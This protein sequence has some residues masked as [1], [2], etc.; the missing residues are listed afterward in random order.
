M[1]AMDSMDSRSQ[2]CVYLFHGP[3]SPS[4]AWEP[5]CHPGQAPYVFSVASRRVGLP[6]SS[7]Y[8]HHPVII[9]RKAGGQARPHCK[10]KGWPEKSLEG[11][12]EPFALGSL[13]LAELVS[14]TWGLP[15]VFPAQRRGWSWSLPKGRRV[16][17]QDP[18]GELSLDSQQLPEG[19]GD[20]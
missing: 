16:R 18:L 14:L 20:S 13:V 9:T 1:A 10:V 4:A 3:L 2:A 5:P 6:E 11:A 17:V 12:A 8:A 15:S 7:C 19:C